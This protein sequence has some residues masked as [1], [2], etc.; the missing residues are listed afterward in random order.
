MIPKIIHQIWLG[1]ERPDSHSA[2]IQGV[3]SINKDI[4]CY[5]W[6]E[7]RLEE[8]DIDPEFLLKDLGNYASVTNL[9]RLILLGKYGGIYLDTDCECL[10]PLGELCRY[11]AFAA[12][13]DGDRICNAV[14][15]SE[16][17]HPWIKWQLDNF[18]SFGHPQDAAQGV[19]LASA[20][21]RE[22]L[23]IIPTKWVYPFH[24]DTPMHERKPHPDSFIAHHWQG[25][26]VKK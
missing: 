24:Y 7:K 12:I 10:K 5:L 19:Y 13:Q 6:D 21:P 4:P 20:A 18:W 1:G 14:M 25:S 9:I 22:G 17:D 16:P 3:R 26:W 11:K 15:G 2:F 8:E 23:T